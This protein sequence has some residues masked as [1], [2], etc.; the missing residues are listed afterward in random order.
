MGCSLSALV[1][2]NVREVIKARLSRLSAAASEL[3]AAGAVLGR[4]FGSESL[5]GVAGLGEAEGLRGLDELVGRRLLLEEGGSQEVEGSPLY[6]GATYSFSHEKIRQVA[7]TESGQ[8]RRSVLHRRAFEVLEKKGA[9]PAKLAHHALAGGL[10]G[11]SFTYSVAAGHDAAEV[12]AAR[13]AVVHYERAREVL[14]AGQRPGGAVKPSIPDVEH[15]YTQ[16]GR[17][18]EM[19]DEWEKAHATYETMLAFAREAGEARLVVISLDHLAAFLFDKEHDTRRVTALLEEALK[20]AEEADLAEARVETECNLVDVMTLRTREIERSRPLAE[21][22]LASAR[23]VEQPGPGSA[24][25]DRA[26]ATGDLRGQAGGVGG[27]RQEGP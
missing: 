13:D 3:L 2:N 12:F 4:G 9:P 5:V 6:F 21:K 24:D 17:A 10:A 18:Y 23:A 20:V 19:A 26:G 7:Y 11:P 8:A 15:L 16:S 22:A 27:P 14:D 1:P 25:L